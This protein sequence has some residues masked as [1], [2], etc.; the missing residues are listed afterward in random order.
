MDLIPVAFLTDAVGFL[1]DELPID[2]FEVDLA[3]VSAV[4]SRYDVDFGGPRAGRST[5]KI[6]RGGS[7]PS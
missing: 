4:A 3:E 5:A 2:P 7:R 6:G 1:T